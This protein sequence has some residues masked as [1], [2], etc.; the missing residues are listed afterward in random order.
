M[1]FIVIII[2]DVGH[3]FIV[4]YKKNFEHLNRFMGGRRRRRFQVL[5]GDREIYRNYSFH[6]SR[7]TSVYCGGVLIDLLKEVVVDAPFKRSNHEFKGV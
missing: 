7:G 1:L 2:A 6:F 4:F 3:C 5:Y